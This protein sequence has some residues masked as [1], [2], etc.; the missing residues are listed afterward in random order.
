MN[1][2]HN[3]SDSRLKRLRDPRGYEFETTPNGEIRSIYDRNGARIGCAGP[4][5][6]QP[7]VGTHSGMWRRAA[8]PKLPLW[9]ETE[10]DML[11]AT[12]ETDDG[13]RLAVRSLLRK[14][15]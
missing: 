8:R 5:N 2:N 7:A 15:A 6:G 10:Q 11:L 14:G 3:Y 9:S 13:F 1:Y 12:L 4:H